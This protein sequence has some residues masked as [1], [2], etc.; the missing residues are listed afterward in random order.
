M[1]LAASRHTPLHAT[2]RFH[3]H[4]EALQGLNVTA[5]Q[6]T[7]DLLFFPEHFRSLCVIA[8]LAVRRAATLCPDSIQ[9]LGMRVPYVPV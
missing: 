2:R 6:D 5:P 9:Y 8:S 4:G 1:G 7:A 3:A